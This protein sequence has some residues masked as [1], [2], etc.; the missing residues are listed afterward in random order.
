LQ[1]ILATGSY[2]RRSIEKLSEGEDADAADFP[3]NL[4]D[5]LNFFKFLFNNFT[6]KYLGKNKL[7][8]LFFSLNY[9]I[10]F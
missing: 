1:V 4:V 3:L 10:D 5:F 6:L 2:R 9:I 8:A 7:K